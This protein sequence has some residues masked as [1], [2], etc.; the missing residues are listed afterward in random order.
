MNLLEWPSADA[1]IHARVGRPSHDA[2]MTVRSDQRCAFA[3]RNADRRYD[4][5]TNELARNAP[6][7]EAFW[8]PVEARLMRLARGV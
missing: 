1:R 7:S 8:R 6:A 5:S 2:V 3:A 4:E